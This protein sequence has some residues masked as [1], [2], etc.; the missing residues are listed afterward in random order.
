M[1]RTSIVLALALALVVAAAA[2]DKVDILSKAERPGVEILSVNGRDCVVFELWIRNDGRW[3][4][5]DAG[6][7]VEDFVEFKNV[8]REKQG[9]RDE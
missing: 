1:K 7:A 4:V 2:G 5:V 3:Q 8:T 6:I 9:A